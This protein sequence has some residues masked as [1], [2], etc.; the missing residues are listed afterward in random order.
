LLIDTKEKGSLFLS[1]E[2]RIIDHKYSSPTPPLVCPGSN[3]P[4]LLIWA[5]IMLLALASEMCGAMIYAV[6][7]QSFKC[8]CMVWLDISGTTTICPRKH[9]LSGMWVLLPSETQDEKNVG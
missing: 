8:N 5:L 7:W 9:V 3:L 1:L 6:S 2:N 4:L